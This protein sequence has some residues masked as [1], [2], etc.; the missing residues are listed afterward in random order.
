MTR[1]EA[2]KRCA[3]LNLERTDPERRWIAR[4]GD[5]D[6]WLTVQVRLPGLAERAPL[7]PTIEARPRPRDADDPRSPA[8]RLI[9]PMG[10]IPG[11]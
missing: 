9:P 5:G 4:R 7:T 1:A 2:E 3:E 6:D 10:P 8:E 11:G